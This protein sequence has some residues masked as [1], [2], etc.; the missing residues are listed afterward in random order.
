[1]TIGTE[2][3]SKCKDTL[4]CIVDN[5]EKPTDNTYAALQ[6]IVGSVEKVSILTTEISKASSEKSE[7]S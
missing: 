7:G 1:M 4:Q 5:A 2:L 3:T 6:E